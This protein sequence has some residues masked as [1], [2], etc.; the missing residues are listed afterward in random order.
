MAPRRTAKTTATKKSTR[1]KKATTKV[2]ALAPTPLKVSKAL[3][4][5]GPPRTP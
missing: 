4:T 3:K 2:A 5:I 1:T